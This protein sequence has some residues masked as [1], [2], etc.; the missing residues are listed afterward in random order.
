MFAQGS[1]SFAPHGV[2][3]LVL[4]VTSVA[5]GYYVGRHS[6]STQVNI[7]ANDQLEDDD[8]SNDGDLGSIKAGMLE[9]CK[10]VQDF[11]RLRR[12]VVLTD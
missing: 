4:S 1:T 5:I 2:A 8:E 6:T 9:P 12:L 11:I 10:L 7:P 3:L